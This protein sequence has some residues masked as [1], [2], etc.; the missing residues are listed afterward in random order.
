MLT[1]TEGRMSRPL[2]E[3]QRQIPIS[4]YSLIF[5]FPKFHCLPSH[6]SLETRCSG[7]RFWRRLR[8]SC[9]GCRRAV[10]CWVRVAASFLYDNLS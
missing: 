8:R 2:S 3:E 1:S 7:R 10:F 6:V 9:A 5:L 4:I